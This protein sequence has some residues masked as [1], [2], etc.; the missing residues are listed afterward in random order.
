MAASRKGWQAL[1]PAYRLRLSRA[2]ITEK[3]YKTG[4]SL[5][6]ARGKASTPEHGAR[7]A[8][9]NPDKFRDYIARNPEAV[10]IET[11]K[12]LD[13]AYANSKNQLGS[14][15]SYRP[16]QVKANIYGGIRKAQHTDE[17]PEVEVKG[18]TYEQ[19]E[20]TAKADIEELRSRASDQSYQ[21]PWWYH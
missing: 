17:S 21:N 18:M 12:T 9:R 3:Q 2:G 1:S 16:N 19:A 13:K 7:E 8:L 5:R 11:N 4:K 6:A 15:H 20:W 10:A 14:Y